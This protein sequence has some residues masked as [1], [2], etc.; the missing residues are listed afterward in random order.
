MAGRW[1]SQDSRNIRVREKSELRMDSTSPLRRLIGEISRHRM[2]WFVVVLI[3]VAAL[4]YLCAVPFGVFAPDNRLTAPETILAIA[5]LGGFAFFD[6]IAE[7]NVGPLGVKL[8]NL[9]K[10]QVEL[11]KE[12]AGIRDRV[13]K[14]FLNTMAKSMYENLTK[15]S[16]GG[17]EYEK[18]DDLIREIT[19]LRD[20]GYVE[21]FDA[22]QIRPRGEAL[23]AF[24]R[25]TPLGR[26]F[27]ELREYLA[28]LSQ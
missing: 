14:L 28:E 8:R 13:T 7:F 9:E 4:V 5:L 2:R 23:E 22:H 1:K 26:E 16:E 17:F 3:T 6:A 12:I 24:V 27:L 11:E 20:A 21:D 25:I 19:H 18:T 10:R 15:L